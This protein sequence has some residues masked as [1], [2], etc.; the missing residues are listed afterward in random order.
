MRITPRRPFAAL[1]PIVTTLIALLAVGSPAPHAEA[2]CSDCW[3]ETRGTEIVNAQTGQPVR[4]RAVGLGYWLLQEGYM[5]NPAG[6]NGCPGTQWQMKGQYLDEGRTIEEVEAFYKAWRENF[7]TK[8]DID[9]IASLGFNSV[10]LPMHYDLF[11]TDAQRA[12]RHEV[13]GDLSFGHDRYKAALR[14]WLDSGTL[15][16]S[17]DLEGFRMIDRLVEWCEANGMYV[18]LDMHAAP[19]AQG[20]DL[21]ICDG[22]WANNLWEFP[23]FQDT[24]DAIWKGIS[25]RYK[26]EPRI[27]MYEFINEPNNVPGGGPAIQALTQRLI[28]TIRNNGDN[29]I[30]VVHGNGWGNDYT[31]MEPFTFTPNWGLVYSAHRYWFDLDTDYDQG[32]NPNVINRLGNMLAFRDRHNVPVWVGET[33]EN[34]NAWLAQNIANLDAAGIGWCHWTYKRHD[35]RE[36]AALGRIG[37]NWPTDGA[38]AM[39]VVL[40]SIKFENFIPN[41]NTIAAVTGNLP[42]PGAEGCFPSADTCE[43]P[44]GETVWLRGNND[45][46]ISTMGGNVPMRCARATIGEQEL[47]TIVDAGNGKVALRGSNNRY[48]S[49][50][51]GEAPMICDRLA[52]QEWE[53]FDWIDLGGDAVALRGSNGRFVTSANGLGPMMCDR[54]TVQAWETF[55]VGT[56]SACT[57]DLALPFGLLDLADIAA[58]A[59]AFVDA[60]P[61]AD[62]AEPLGVYDLADITVFVTSFTAG[63]P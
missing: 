15:A 12:V 20:S 31:A 43:P 29:H 17:N 37:G 59:S 4:L 34:N 57:A 9:Y 51:N 27:A 55:T 46:Y 38:F 62:L 6:C 49:S 44:I 35:W 61:T 11:L 42:Q 8:D 30:L 48:V 60:R 33:G 32:G 41:P 39:P 23:V 24:L 7:I 28:S 50:E 18:I 13:I 36:N 63:C 58:F 25:D 45:A 21:N 47:F 26:A 5:L 52:I 10:R 1:S 16:T 40:D 2:Q 22:F 3:L 53:A 19:G 14:D 56:G 54:E